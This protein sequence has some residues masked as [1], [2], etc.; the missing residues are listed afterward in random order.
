MSQLESDKEKHLDNL[1]KQALECRSC[2]LRQGCRGV[3]FGEGNPFSPI[4]FVGEGPGQTEDELGQPFV[5]KAGQLLNKILKASG[6]GRQNVYITN[7]VKC[8]PENNRTPTADEMAACLPWLRSQYKIIAP[9]HMVLLGLAAT[10]GIL[11][12]KVKMAE[13]RGRWIEKGNLKILATY[14]PAA[15]LRNPSLKKAAWDDFQLIK[16]TLTDTRI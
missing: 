2:H 9:S 6:I 14:H 4:M 3:V 15:L 5:G 7:I 12:P 1:R 13:V 16:Q 8:R 11:D 10:H